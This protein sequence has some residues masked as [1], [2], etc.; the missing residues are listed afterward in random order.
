MSSSA[1]T[2]RKLS[3]QNVTAYE[4]TR[5]VQVLLASCRGDLEMAAL[6]GGRAGLEPAFIQSQVELC[7]SRGE[8]Y[9]AGQGDSVDGV[10]LAYAPGQDVQES[11]SSHPPQTLDYV[12][13]LSPEMQQWWTSHFMPKFSELTNIALGSQEGRKATWYIKTIAVHPDRQRRG[14]G[15][16]LMQTVLRQADASSR[17]ACLE[18]NS[19]SMVRVFA[20][21][22]FR[23]RATK[24]FGSYQ[25]GFILFLMT[26][27]PSH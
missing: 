10:L 14:I 18:V 16:Q 22:G 5:I 26:R 11:S 19:D 3:A 8:V 25:G 9:V 21:F 20:K 12:S 15:R 6:T 23:V 13:K 2:V 4:K 27:E 17:K 7:L 1:V 24:N